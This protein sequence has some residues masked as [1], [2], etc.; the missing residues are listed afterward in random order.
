M[1][2]LEFGLEVE[3]GEEVVVQDAFARAG[4]ELVEGFQ[5]VGDECVA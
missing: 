4:E 2:E 3:W 5:D 1:G